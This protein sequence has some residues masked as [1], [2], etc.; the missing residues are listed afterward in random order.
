VIT[1][2]D[3]T[4]PTYD[5]PADIIFYKDAY[6]NAD[7]ST[8][9][10][11]EPT[12]VADNCSDAA[13]ITV[14]YTDSEKTS[15]CAGSYSFTRTW[16][17]VDECGN[18]SLSDSVQ[19][20]TVSD[21][22]R[23]IF[24]TSA[25]SWIASQQADR[26]A[27]SDGCV[28]KVP[29]LTSMVQNSTSDNCTSN[30][31]DFTITQD[32]LA[33]TTITANTS[34][35]VTAT[36]LCNNTSAEATV[37]I[38]VPAAISVTTPTQSWTYDGNTHDSTTFSLTSG[39]LSVTG[40]E[41]GS[42]VTLPNG[43]IATVTVTGSVQ[44]VSDGLVSNVATVTVKDAS[45][46]DVTCYYMVNTTNGTLNINCKSVTV[47]VDDS[48]KIVN[49]PEPTFTVSIT[50]LVPGESESL[51][52]YDTPLTREPGED[53]GLY[54]IVV[55]G[56]ETQGNYCVTF[57]NGILA[58]LPEGESETVHCYADVV[59]PTA[60][61]PTN[62][63]DLCEG[64]FINLTDTIP[65]IDPDETQWT[66]CDTMVKYIY[67][68]K[69]CQGGSHEWVYTYLVKHN[70]VPTIA[71][72]PSK[73]DTV[74]AEH[75]IVNGN[76]VYKYPELRGTVVQ[77]TA[78]CTGDADVF[79]NITYTQSSDTSEVIEQTDEI[80]Y[81][82]VTVEAIDGCGN[83]NDT[84]IYVKVPARLQLAISPVGDDDTVKVTCFG[85]NNGSAILNITGGTEDYLYS[86]SVFHSGTTITGLSVPT[87]LNYSD[88]DEDNYGGILHGDTVFTV[89][90]A[91]GCSASDTVTVQSPDS[92]YWKHCPNNIT[93]CCDPGQNYATVI[94]GVHFTVPTLSTMANGANEYVTH[95]VYPTLNHYNVGNKTIVYETFNECDEFPNNCV[96]TITVL[97]N[98]SIDFANPA[99]AS[100]DACLGQPITEIQL[101]HENSVFGDVSGLPY[102]VSLN[103]ETGIISGM[104]TDVP[105]VY[106]YKIAV[107]STDTSDAGNACGTDTL[108]GTITLM[109]TVTVTL[110]GKTQTNNYDG[111]SHTVTGY[112]VDNISNPNYTA[113]DFRLA[114]GI[115]ASASRTNV[116]EGED[117]D[118]QTDMG[119]T[120][121]SFVN[122]N[123]NF[124]R[125]T[126]VVTDGWQKIEPIDVVVTITEHGDTLDYDGA[127]HMVT[128]YD[129]A[130]SNSLYTVGDFTFSGTDTVSG[131]N[132]GE[133]PM[134]LSSTDF[135]NT[136]PNFDN[137]TFTIVDAQLKIKDRKS[138]V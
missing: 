15:T 130:I 74:D 88:E 34:V 119:L 55:T 43:D 108:R 11:G 120:D 94:P 93:V 17:V 60:Y 42:T 29:D 35:S 101:A 89:T 6:C 112:V 25:T 73:N 4:R 106:N 122:I 116:V 21:T 90:D 81:K 58:I 110:H 91:H 41:S 78:Y 138:V 97:P 7:T 54:T 124:C 32:P 77:A 31:T 132:V 136:N 12:S 123:P 62:I 39:G 44:N 63:P 65:E 134:E 9:A 86:G 76:C 95:T 133:Y 47:T 128:G 70:I 10:A 72:N 87:T 51:I 99:Q 28:Y 27:T 38:T 83:S 57:N 14:S 22:M 102:G 85:Q 61:I 117:T 115:V 48:T 36:D 24:N 75:A 56:N 104:P 79:K 98:P 67:R 66:K 50:G 49:A 103:T 107:N 111:T 3:T 20:I 68:Y 92:L 64:G 71:I 125:V 129:V 127:L 131:T 96:F 33:G 5:R 59:P 19:T 105:G 113:N 30:S 126:F 46:N 80:Q 135:A 40:Q 18:V 45:D 109:D 84:L 52:S 53:E 82:E 114:T 100:Q 23:P 13:H 26:M 1:V 8:T 118:G 137:V 69:D 121:T 16:R 37:T 2:S